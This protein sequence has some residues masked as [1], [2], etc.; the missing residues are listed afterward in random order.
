MWVCWKNVPRLYVPVG[1]HHPESPW[2][3]LLPC[4]EADG[5]HLNCIIH[6]SQ[7]E[8]RQSHSHQGPGVEWNAPEGPVEFFLQQSCPR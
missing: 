5:I 1:A 2:K 7:D 4:S 8:P 6:T 3:A